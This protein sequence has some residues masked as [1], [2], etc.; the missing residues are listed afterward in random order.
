M[1]KPDFFAERFRSFV[2]AQYGV[3]DPH[4]LPERQKLEIGDAYYAGAS[5]GF[6]HG[7]GCDDDEALD[8]H[9]ELK[10][11]GT[12]FVKRYADAGL[13]TRQRRS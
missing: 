8:A 6:Y 3:A 12:R 4:D 2:A 7:F 1:T 10:D 11:F 5:V 9:A 13:P